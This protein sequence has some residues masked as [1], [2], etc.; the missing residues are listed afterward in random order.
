MLK[1]EVIQI[2]E[3]TVPDK[4]F[5]RNTNT[6]NIVI[7]VDNFYKLCNV[8]NKYNFHTLFYG[9]IDYIKN[10]KNKFEYNVPLAK[11]FKQKTN[12]PLKL[13]SD[14]S[15]GLTIIQQFFEK[16]I[17]EI[18]PNVRSNLLF[19]KNANLKQ[20]K[21]YFVFPESK[22]NSIIKLAIPYTRYAKLMKYENN[23]EDF[24]KENWNIY[25]PKEEGAL[26]PKLENPYITILIGYD[27]KVFLDKISQL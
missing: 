10:N 11:Q 18:P 14:L 19:S 15:N 1:F 22:N 17:L 23:I 25:C 8:A 9:D 26:I 27:C 12:A 16:L 4:I 20:L 6:Y 7:S 2:F 21:L 24:I 3:E 13:S 5:K